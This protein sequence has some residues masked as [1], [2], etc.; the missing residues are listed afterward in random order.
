MTCGTR[1]NTQRLGVA[2]HQVGSAQCTQLH[3]VFQHAQTAIRVG[4]HGSLVPAHIAFL[5][6]SAQGGQGIP[7]PNRL[8]VFAVHHL[9]QLDGEF[10]VS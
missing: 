1:Q 2:R 10:D 9:Q 4:E 7:N 3:T 5:R 8:V 6:E